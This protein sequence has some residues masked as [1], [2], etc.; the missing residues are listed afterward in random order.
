MV[1]ELPPEERY[2]RICQLGEGTFGAFIRMLGV[3]ASILVIVSF[4]HADDM[5]PLRVP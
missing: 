4:S 3:C 2:R 5:Y 1:A